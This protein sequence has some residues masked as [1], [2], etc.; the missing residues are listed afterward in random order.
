MYCSQICLKNDNDY[1]LSHLIYV[2]TT[3][4]YTEDD[5]S[6]SITNKLPPPRLR[7]LYPSKIPE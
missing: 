4:L 7:P 5:L 3:F 1:G 6:S 2:I